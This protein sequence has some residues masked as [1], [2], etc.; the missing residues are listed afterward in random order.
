MV[1]Q[2]M[3]SFAIRSSNGGAWKALIVFFLSA[4]KLYKETLAENIF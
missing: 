1:S 3:A 2:S 4:A